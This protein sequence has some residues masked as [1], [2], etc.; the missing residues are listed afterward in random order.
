LVGFEIMSGFGKCF[1]SVLSPEAQRSLEE[2]KEQ[3]KTETA[4]NPVGPYSQAIRANGLVFASGQI[5]LDPATNQIVQGGIEAQTQRVLQNLKA[6]LTAAG[7]NMDLVVKTTV[8]LADMS[9]FGA[10][11]EIYGKFFVL[12]P[13]ARSTIEVSRLPRDVRVEIDVIA[14]EK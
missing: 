2:M 9:E 1:D 12:T 8:Y 7:S 4:P 10:M 6:V 13:P 3:V 14:L 5:A 11:N